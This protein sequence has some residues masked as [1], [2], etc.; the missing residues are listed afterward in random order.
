MHD[1]LIERAEVVAQVA[2]SKKGGDVAFYQPAARRRFCGGSPPAITACCRSRPSLRIWREMLAATVRIETPFAVAVFAPAEGA[3]LLGSRPRPLRQP[4]ADVGLSLDRPGDPRRDRRRGR[5]R[6]PADAAGG[7]PRSVVAPFGCREDDNAPRVIARLPFG[8]RGNAR[9][10]GSD[11]LVDRTRRTAGDRRRPHLS[12]LPNRRPTSAGRDFSACCRPPGSP[13]PSSPHGSHAEGDLSLVEID[14]FV[15]I[16]DPRLA[17]F[18]HAAR[19][20]AVS[21]LLP[22]GG[23]A[24]PLPAALLPGA[25]KG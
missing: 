9:S 8:P 16:S 5:G 20:G 1:L 19:R 15:P 21:R 14:G 25:A 22:F 23:Y 7:R 11:A 18:Q 24:L 6:H 10:D 3:G 13:A 4:R 12:S 17:G 2:A